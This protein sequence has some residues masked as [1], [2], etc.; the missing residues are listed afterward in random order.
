MQET[1]VDLGESVDQ[2]VEF[3]NQF[4]PTIFR[5]LLILVVVLLATKYLGRGLSRL[6]IRMGVPERRALFPVTLLHIAVLMVGA[7][8][9][10][11]AL[12]V[13]V[14]N[15]F[16]ALFGV[17]L[18]LL[19][20]FIVFRPYLPGLPMKEG[21]TVSRGSLFGSVERITF[22]HTMIRN[23]DGRT[24]FIPNHKMLNEPLFNMSAY[25][26][27]RADVEFCVSYNEDLDKVREVVGGVLEADERVLE[28]PPPIVVVK[29][30][31]P[32]Y[33]SMLARFWLDGE[34]FLG[35]KWAVSEEI[36]RAMTREGIR[37]GVPRIEVVST[38]DREESTEH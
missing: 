4:G 18:A 33:R 24:A 29:E 16:R 31:E 12:G 32:S 22:A 15:L 2:V 35:A 11:A 20:V 21:D 7:L 3:S 13:P 26:F 38:D 36:D 9:V 17:L 37:L 27:R 14:M 34:G 19:A 8:V 30:L 23:V 28:E 10:L 25:P 5:S 6:L 1:A